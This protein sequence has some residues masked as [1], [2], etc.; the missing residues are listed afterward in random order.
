MLIM[1]SE[2]R[3]SWKP[4]CH[5]KT[6]TRVGTVETWWDGSHNW[7]AAVDACKLFRRDQQGG[8]GRQGLV[9][10]VG[11]CLNCFKVFN[12]S[13]DKVNCLGVRI[14]QKANKAENPGLLKN[15]QQ[16]SRGR[17]NTLISSWDEVSQLLA[18]ILLGDFS[19]AGNTIQQKGNNLCD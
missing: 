19:L 4:R 5:R 10:N 13:D 17:W 15:T 8:K 11:E 2:N 7:S 18:H 16:G 9:L 6:V 14:Q 1:W 12:G 3:S